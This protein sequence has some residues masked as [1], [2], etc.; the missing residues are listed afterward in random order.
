MSLKKSGYKTSKQQGKKCRYLPP[1]ISA[2]SHQLVRGIPF[3][4]EECAV[5]SLIQN[6]KLVTLCGNRTRKKSWMTR[7]GIAEY[8]CEESL[9]GLNK[10]SVDSIMNVFDICR[11]EKPDFL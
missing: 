2:I 4:P 7:S 9:A 10:I 8:F 6:I 1:C 11:G 5:S 3:N